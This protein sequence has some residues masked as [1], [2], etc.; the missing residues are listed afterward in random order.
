MRIIKCR[1][2]P[3]SDAH[4]GHIWYNKV[5]TCDLIGLIHIKMNQRKGEF[6]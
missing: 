5:N 3:F 2:L 4:K 1:D 6:T